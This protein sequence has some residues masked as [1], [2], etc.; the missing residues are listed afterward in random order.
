MER[1]VELDKSLNLGD[2]PLE[3]AIGAAWG[4]VP[5]LR[6]STERNEREEKG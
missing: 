3:R 1:E 4:C 6:R 5:C 2:F